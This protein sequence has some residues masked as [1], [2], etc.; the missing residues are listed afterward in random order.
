M[1]VIL[2]SLNIRLF[3]SHILAVANNE[4]YV[5]D[6]H[7]KVIHNNVFDFFIFLFIRIC[8]LTFALLVLSYC[9]LPSSLPTLLPI[10]ILYI[11]IL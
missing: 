2:E 5:D 9:F 1:P 10:C 11:F 8:F 4:P 6:H 7:L 3:T